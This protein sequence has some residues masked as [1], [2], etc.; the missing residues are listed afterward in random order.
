MTIKHCRIKKNTASLRNPPDRNIPLMKCLLKLFNNIML[1][2]LVS[3][4]KDW[5][6]D[7]KWEGYNTSRKANDLSGLLPRRQ[8]NMHSEHPQHML[9]GRTYSWALK[10]M[11]LNA[12][13][14][15]CN[16]LL[17]RGWLYRSLI[18][19]PKL[20]TLLVYYIQHNILP[21]ETVTCYVG[22]VSCQSSLSLFP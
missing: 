11:S 10:N 7:K 12:G 2:F 19:L 16:S 3:M 13:Q 5:S 17:W 20:P 6:R 14:P 1:A 21:V 18:Y 8:C 9:E 4:C 22:A 15:V